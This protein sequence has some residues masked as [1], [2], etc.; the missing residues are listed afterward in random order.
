[1]MPDPIP[2]CEVLEIVAPVS[3]GHLSV[4]QDLLVVADWWDERSDEERAYLCR[5]LAETDFLPNANTLVVSSEAMTRIRP[6][7]KNLQ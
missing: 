1:M 4:A 5:A 7:V 3:F 6:V 2:N